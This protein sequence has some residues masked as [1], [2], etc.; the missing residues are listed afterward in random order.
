MPRPGPPE[1][2]VG[3]R[4]APR[5]T[6]VAVDLAG[7]AQGG[8]DDSPGVL[9]LVFAPEP[10][11]VTVDGVVEQPLIGLLAG[12]ED[13]LVRQV[14]SHRMADQL[15]ARALACKPSVTPSFWPRRNTM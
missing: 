1:Q 12:A 10:E 2:A 7:A 11:P 5:A 15:V 14:E 9:D 4:W 3:F 8:F 13:A 6:R